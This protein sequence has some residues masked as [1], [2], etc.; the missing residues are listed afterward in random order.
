MLKKILP[1][2][3]DSTNEEQKKKS[4]GTRY[5]HYAPDTPVHISSPEERQELLDT[6]I[7]K[8]NACFIGLQVSIKNDLIFSFASKKEFAK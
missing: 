6:I 7:F 5:K 3:T 4:P 2:T 8:K 1:H